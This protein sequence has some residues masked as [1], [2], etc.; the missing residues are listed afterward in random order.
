MKL[1]PKDVSRGIVGTI[2]LTGSFA[3]FALLVLGEMPPEMR[4]IALMVTGAVISYINTIIGW[5]FGSSKGSDKK[6]EAMIAAA[7]NGRG[8]GQ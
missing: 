2:V 3:W 1:L 5:A 7:V 4:D 6:D 8:G